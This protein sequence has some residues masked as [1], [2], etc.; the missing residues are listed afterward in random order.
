MPA[1]KIINN[2]LLF[3]FSILLIITSCKDKDDNK[4]TGDQPTIDSTKITPPKAAFTGGSLDTLWMLSS[5]FSQ[6]PEKIIF[7][8]TIDANTKLTLHGWKDKGGSNQFDTDP[9][10]K[11]NNGRSGLLQYGPDMYFGNV[12]LQQSDVAKIINKIKQGNYTYVLLIPSII[13]T[14][15]IG[16]SVYVSNDDPRITGKVLVVDPT[17]ADL[18]PSPPKNY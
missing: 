15:H 13:N 5:D 9:N 11:F 10:Y 14:K 4:K 2:Y 18:N 7:S 6:K 17:G 16:Y 3:L 8:F 12:V 1:S